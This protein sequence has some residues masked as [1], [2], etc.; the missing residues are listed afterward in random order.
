MTTL[1]EQLRAEARSCP[2]CHYEIA[3]PFTGRCP[4]CLTVVPVIDPGCANCIH[5]AGCP[6]SSSRKVAS[7]VA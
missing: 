5:G 7:K 3:S 2:V 4:R 1:K 6:V